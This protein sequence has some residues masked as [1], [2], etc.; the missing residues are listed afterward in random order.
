MGRG[1][2]GMREDGLIFIGQRAARSLMGEG[3]GREQVGRGS[4]LRGW[5]TTLYPIS[6]VRRRHRSHRTNQGLKPQQPLGSQCWVKLKPANPLNLQLD[7]RAQLAPFNPGEQEPREFRSMQDKAEK[8]KPPLL[9]GLLVKSLDGL[10]A[11]ELH[12]ISF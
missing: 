6:L 11:P 9:P 12:L 5:G 4:R 1:C 8:L 7:K 10:A 3:V 2:G